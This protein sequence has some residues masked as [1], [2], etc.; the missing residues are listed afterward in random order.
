MRVASFI[1]V[2]CFASLAPAALAQAPISYGGA[3]QSGARV[4][5]ALP[6]A[7][8]ADNGGVLDLTRP[9]VRTERDPDLLN[10]PPAGADEAA[11][12]ARAAAAPAQRPAWLEQERVGPPYEANGRLYAPTPEPGY[13]QSGTASWYGPDFHGQAG[14]NG[15]RFDQDALSAAH[16]TLPLNSLVQVTNLQNGRELILRVTDR[17]PF[18]GE[19]LIDVSRRA[20]DVLGFQQNGTTRV[21]VRYLGP[22]P[23]RYTQTASAPAAPQNTAPRNA[24]PLEGAPFAQRPAFAAREPALRDSPFVVQIGAFSAEETA[25]RIGAAVAVAG[26]VQIEPRSTAR[27]PLYRVRVAGFES[28]DAAEAAR[29]QV[30]A[31]GYPEAIVAAR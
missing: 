28:R 26:P 8:A 3:G 16:P 7:D 13:E 11:A 29:S 21:H 18:V 25:R 23:R 22:A 17:G 27:G 30:A 31:L 2:S 9:R 24:P 20:A 6:A 19:R 1:F 5:A 15:E 10:P 4:Y 12:P 14:A